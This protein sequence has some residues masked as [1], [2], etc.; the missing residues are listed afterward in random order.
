M[1]LIG[2]LRSIR[3]T[4]GMDKLVGVPPF[5]PIFGILTTLFVPVGEE[6][7]Q[8]PERRSERMKKEIGPK[9]DSI[10]LQLLPR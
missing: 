7:L 2:R 3:L 4:W 5:L 9:P 6:K 10:D 1:P 8:M